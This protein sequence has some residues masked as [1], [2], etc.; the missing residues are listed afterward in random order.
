MDNGY[1]PCT[2]HHAPYTIHHTPYTIHPTLFCRSALAFAPSSAFATPSCPFCEA[3]T[4][5]VH[6]SCRHNHT[7]RACIRWGGGAQ[8]TPR[9]VGEGIKRKCRNAIHK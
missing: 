2:M 1:L 3:Y 6:P 5:A 4:N 9:P 8:C 7:V